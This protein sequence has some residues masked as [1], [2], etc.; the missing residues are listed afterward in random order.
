MASPKFL[1]SSSGGFAAVWV[2]R[3][4]KNSGNFW[5]RGRTG[6]TNSLMRRINSLFGFRLITVGSFR[7]PPIL[8]IRAGA[9]PRKSGSKT[10]IPC[11]IAC[12]QGNVNRRRVRDRL[13]PPS[14]VDSKPDL[15]RIHP[16][17]GVTKL[18]ALTSFGLVYGYAAT[19]DVATFM[20]D[21]DRPGR[22]NGDNPR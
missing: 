21:G 1:L 6:K 16:C 7:R 18:L 5:R 3:V 10:A 13:R 12:Y 14:V 15:H 20:T 4:R 22:S 2:T 9:R 19:A 17:V 11:Y 8:Q